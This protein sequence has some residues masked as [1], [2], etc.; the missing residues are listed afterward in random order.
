MSTNHVSLKVSDG[1]TMQAYTSIP[2]GKGPFPG[3]I[4]FQEA[5]GVN[6]HIRD[7]ADRFAKEGCTVIAPEL[8]HHTAPAG[9]EAPYGGDFS[10]IMPH[11]QALTTEGLAADAKACYDWLQQQSTVQHN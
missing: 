5:F 3:I 4:L 6:A 9:F 7:V 11:F 8:F 2:A 10:L 1:T